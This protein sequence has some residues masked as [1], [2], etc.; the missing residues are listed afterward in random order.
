MNKK[1]MPMPVSEIYAFY[2]VAYISKNK[3]YLVS[4]ACLKRRFLCETDSFFFF[5]AYYSGKFF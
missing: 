3:K 1:Y 5:F 2:L 4:H